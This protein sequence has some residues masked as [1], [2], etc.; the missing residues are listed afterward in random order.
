VARPARAA[1]GRAPRRH[2][3]GDES[4]G[5]D[6]Q[7]NADERHRIGRTD[8]EE[9][10]VQQARRGKRAGQS[11]DE[12]DADERH[13][14]ANGDIDRI[15]RQQQFIGSLVHKVLSAGTLLDPFKLNGFLDVATS[16]LTADKGLSGG[17]L[18]TL[19]LRLRHFNSGGVLFQTVP[20]A[21]IGG[22]RNGA[23]VVLLDEAK[24]ETMFAALRA[25]RAP[26]TPASP[27]T[28]CSANP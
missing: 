9:Q 25:D 4:D 3:C 22:R 23:S 27:T 19:A 26:G 11:N 10:A 12:T 17:D 28:G 6:Q 1:T 24:A 15:A 8:A 18:K 13:G 16:S 5:G 14:L 2:P 21:D 7:H 20:I